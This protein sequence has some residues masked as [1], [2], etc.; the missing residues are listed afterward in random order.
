MTI[1]LTTT[2]LQATKDN[3]VCSPAVDCSLKDSFMKSP[4]PQKDVCKKVNFRLNNKSETVVVTT[5]ADFRQ[6]NFLDALCFHEG[7]QQWYPVYFPFILVAMALVLL[8]IDNFWVM[9]PRTSSALNRFVTLT[10]ECYGSV[11]SHLDLFQELSK[12]SKSLQENEEDLPPDQVEV[13]VTNGAESTLLESVKPAN[14]KSTGEEPTEEHSQEGDSTGEFYFVLSDATKVKTLYERV[15]EFRDKYDG[16]HKLLT[17]VYRVRAAFQILVCSFILLFLFINFPLLADN[18]K[19][20]LPQKVFVTEYEYFL[21]A[22]FIAPY[23]RAVT[24]I[25]A[26]AAL[27]YLITI[28]FAFV[29]SVRNTTR[30]DLFPEVAIVDDKVHIGGDLAFLYSLLEQYNKLYCDRL[31]VFLS[32]RMKANLDKKIDKALYKAA[33]RRGSVKK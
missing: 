12:P 32:K 3:L 7:F 25:F 20:K 13:E 26:A 14:S 29:W 24:L 30:K 5:M 22:R 31:A 33:L 9:Y 15:G 11:A 10:M 17:K 1:A 8:L 6:Y 21:C 16:N 4:A 23:Y 18:M 28:L 19:C 2:A 27:T